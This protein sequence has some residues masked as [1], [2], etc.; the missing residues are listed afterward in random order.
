MAKNKVSIDDVISALR[1]SGAAQEVVKSTLEK[2]NQVVQE[3]QADKQKSPKSK[4]QFVAITFD[5]DGRLA[6]LDIPIFI[7]Q[8]E[9]SAPPQAFIDRI[10][11][12]ANAYHGSRKGRKKPVKTKSE[13]VACI[14][15]KFW[16]SEKEGE[17]TLIKTRE[18]IP[19]LITSNKLEN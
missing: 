11:A 19:L 12:A 3:E 16:N 6:G 4:N 17:K 1:D 7:A 8:I 15:R 13:A 2:L 14:P 9:E 5:D 18:V 10:Q